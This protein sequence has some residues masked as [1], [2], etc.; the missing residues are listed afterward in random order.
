MKFCVIILLYN[1][2]GLKS[3][4]KKGF[5]PRKRLFV[6][7]FTI[8]LHFI[9][10]A[11][12]KMPNGGNE[13]ENL[14]INAGSSSLKYQLIDMDNESVIAK[15]NCERIGIDGL[16]THKANGKEIKANVSFPTHKEAFMEVVKVLTTGE[17]KVIDSVKEISAVGHRVLHGSEV[18]KS[19]TLV[20]D[21][22]IE[23][24]FAFRELGPLH[25]PPQATAMKACQEVFGKG[26]PNVAIFD[27]SFGQTMPEKRTFSAFLM[28]ITRSTP[29][30]ATGSME[31]ATAT[32]ASAT[33]RSKAA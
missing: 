3:S 28:S 14:V 24:I 2:V 15:G 1:V 12:I 6:K 29:S 18:Y 11:S 26:V 9:G 7:N 17:G 27:T 8:F 30:A 32:S 22:V 20:T 16:I 13:N 21:K 23:D 25:N 31:P 5:A 33:A 4:L 19:S 10:T